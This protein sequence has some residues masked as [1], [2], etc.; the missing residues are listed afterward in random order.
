MRPPQWEYRTVQI[1]VSGWLGPK[2]KTGEVDSAFN[3]QGDDG[4]ELVNVLDINVHQGA[5]SALLAVFKRPR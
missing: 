2:I 3:L 1:D 5:T 4:W